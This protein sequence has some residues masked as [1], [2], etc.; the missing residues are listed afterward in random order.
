[1]DDREARRAACALKVP[2]V[3]TLGIV[4]QSTRKGLVQSPQSLVQSLRHAGLRLNDRAIEQAMR[5]IFP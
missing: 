4:L 2:V 5:S 3:G 1:M